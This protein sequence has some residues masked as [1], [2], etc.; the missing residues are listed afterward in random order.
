M[1]TSLSMPY[2]LGSKADNSEV[3][4]GWTDGSAIR[5]T[6]ALQRTRFSFQNPHGSSQPPV[7]AVPSAFTDTR[8]TC[9]M[10]TLMHAMYTHIYEKIISVF[11]KKRIK[12]PVFSAYVIPQLTP[13]HRG[14]LTL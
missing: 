12:V 9:S 2:F 13:I 7:T 4:W 8:H 10:N 11:K 6:A 1:S 14:E 3:L 5:N